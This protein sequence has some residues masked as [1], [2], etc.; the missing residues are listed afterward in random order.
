MIPSISVSDGCPI[1]HPSNLIAIVP[2]C[3][4]TGILRSVIPQPPV[5][6][7]VIVNDDDLSRALPGL[8]HNR[9]LGESLAHPVAVGIK[10]HGVERPNEEHKPS[11][12]SPQQDIFFVHLHHGLEDFRQQVR[13]FSL[14]GH[15]L[16]LLAALGGGF[17]GLLPGF[18]LALE[19]LVARTICPPSLLGLLVT[20][21]FGFGGCCCWRWRWLVVHLLLCAVDEFYQRLS[22]FLDCPLEHACRADA[23]KRCCDGPHEKDEAIHLG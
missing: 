17:H 4:D 16:G 19:S 1:G 15:P 21:V 22:N 11:C 2:P 3:H 14:A 18:G 9:W 12:D 23:A 20:A 6:L 8:Q 7:P 10:A 13:L 5:S